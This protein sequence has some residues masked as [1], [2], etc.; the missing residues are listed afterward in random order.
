M[1]VDTGSSGPIQLTFLSSS[2]VRRLKNQVG[3]T[4]DLMMVMGI[5]SGVRS[6]RGSQTFCVVALYMKPLPADAYGTRC[7]CETEEQS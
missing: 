2:T 7:R 6:I 3:P 5:R 1:L 4:L